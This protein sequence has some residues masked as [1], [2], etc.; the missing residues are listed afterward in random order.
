MGFPHE[1]KLTIQNCRFTTR[2]TVHCQFHWFSLLL[3]YSFWCCS[4]ATYEKKSPAKSLAQSL[5]K[6]LGGGTFLARS[7]IRGKKSLPQ[8]LPPSL[9]K[10]AEKWR[11][12]SFTM[13]SSDNYQMEFPSN[14]IITS[15][16]H[17]FM[18]DFEFS[19]E[20]DV[21]NMKYVYWNNSSC[22]SF[23]RLSQDSVWILDVL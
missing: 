23:E 9:L 5:P 10:G 3:P 2:C 12:G 11:F 19:F 22:I 13:I 15:T 4:A 16:I 1:K 8:S 21:F 14:V 17:L 6:S 18:F 7:S 20:N